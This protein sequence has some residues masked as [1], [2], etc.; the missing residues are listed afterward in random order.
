VRCLWAYGTQVN[1]ETDF[2]AVSAPFQ[3]LVSELGM[4]IASSADVICVS[5]EDV[6]AEVRAHPPPLRPIPL[7]ACSCWPFSCIFCGS[8]SLLSD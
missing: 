8:K 5:P 6:P 4:I 3:K 7:H 2:V 1:C